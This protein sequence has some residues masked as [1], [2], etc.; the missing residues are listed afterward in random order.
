LSITSALHAAL[1]SYLR[2]VVQLKVAP[3]RYSVSRWR[4]KDLAEGQMKW[5]TEERSEESFS[6]ALHDKGEALWKSGPA[7]DLVEAVH[8]E[9]RADPAFIRGILIDLA[10]SYLRN[11]VTIEHDSLVASLEG[12]V[13][14]LFSTGLPAQYNSYVTGIVVSESFSP[15][16][17]ITLRPFSR[18][19]WPGQ[20]NPR[21]PLH[22]ANLAR[23]S[24]LELRGTME[25]LGQ[26]FDPFD[27]KQYQ[28]QKRL[29]QAMRI[30]RLYRLGSVD[31]QLS[32][33]IQTTLLRIPLHGGYID[34][35]TMA[36]GFQYTL[37]ADDMEPLGVMFRKLAHI[38]P[39]KH[40]DLTPVDIAM[41]RYESALAPVRY[42]EER[43]LFAIMGLEALLSRRYEGRVPVTNR[44]IV[45]LDALGETKPLDIRAAVQRAYQFRN[46][47]VHGEAVKPSEA[48]ELAI[49]LSRMLDCLRR[50]IIVFMTLSAEKENLLSKL[51]DA[52]FM[53]NTK[54]SLKDDIAAERLPSLASQTE[55]RNVP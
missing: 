37:T 35:G 39:W 47:F 34:G 13:R 45:L 21:D 10:D 16:P 29:E 38:P 54:T 46:R 26:P 40:D 41:D 3:E 22:A 5:T 48:A 33:T 1:E 6:R 43:L 4:I 2:F 44:L 9:T 24:I 7:E 20:I 53:P 25:P 31:S 51:D 15:A 17:D 30:L 19:D 49:L 52:L 42:T 55:T 18:N 36:T 14:L 23:C 32:L 12:E 27:E 8:H 50:S 11:H 28:W